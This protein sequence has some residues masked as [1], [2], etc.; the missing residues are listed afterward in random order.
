MNRLP[1]AVLDYCIGDKKNTIV[2]PTF[3]RIDEDD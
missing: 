3:S 2:K 1:D